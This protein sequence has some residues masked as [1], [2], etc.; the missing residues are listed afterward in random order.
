MSR[1]CQRDVASEKIIL[2]FCANTNKRVRQAN[3]QECESKPSAVLLGSTHDLRGPSR[4]A[5]E[6]HTHTLSQHTVLNQ[7]MLP[8]RVHTHLHS[9]FSG[10]LACARGIQKC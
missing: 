1:V 5:W 2:C 8:T 6:K 3:T 9:L 4:S 10:C 7:M